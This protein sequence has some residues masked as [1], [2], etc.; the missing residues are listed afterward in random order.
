MLVELR[1]VEVYIEPD[2]ILNKA[3]RDGDLS[4]SDAVCICEEEAGAEEILRSID[5]EDIQKYCND[6]NI[7]LECNFEMMAKNLKG[8]SNEERASLLWFLIGINDDEIKKVVTVELVIPKLNELI[9]VKSRS[10]ERD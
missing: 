1:D 10:Y 7:G 9:Q 5:D 3:L 4:I 6:K 2:D 8:L